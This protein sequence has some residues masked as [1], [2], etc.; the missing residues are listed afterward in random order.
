MEA[1]S[2]CHCQ[3]TRNPGGKRP[4]L[5][6]I[7]K[8]TRI[9]R[10][11][12]EILEPGPLCHEF[13]RLQPLKPMRSAEM[14]HPQSALQWFLP[15]LVFVLKYPLQEVMLEA[16]FSRSPVA[17]QNERWIS[18]PPLSSGPGSG[19]VTSW[20]PLLYAQTLNLATHTRHES[21]GAEKGRLMNSFSRSRGFSAEIGV[22]SM[23]GTSFSQHSATSNRHFE[24]ENTFGTNEWHNDDDS[25]YSTDFSEASDPLK[26]HSR[27]KTAKYIFLTLKQALANSMLIIAI[28]GF[29]FYFI[30]GLTPVDSFYFT[31]VLLTTV[32]Y[33]DI[34]PETTPGKVFATVYLLVAGT[35]LLHNMSLISMIPLELRKRRVEN[36]VLMQF[37]QLDDETLHELATGPLIRRLKLSHQNNGLEECTREMFALAMLVRLGRIKERDVR[38]MLKVFKRLDH[39]NDGKLNSRD[40]IMQQF[41]RRQMQSRKDD[42]VEHDE[43]PP[44]KAK[45][46]TS[47]FRFNRHDA[48]LPKI[49]K[50]RSTVQSGR[51]ETNVNNPEC[52]SLLQDNEHHIERSSTPKIPSRSGNQRAVLD[53]YRSDLESGYGGIQR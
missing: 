32:G 8:T 25:S 1:F 26:P 50:G 47:W 37:E 46:E 38:M 23:V 24:D 30:E 34:Y 9:H 52:I 51:D 29:G 21:L 14:L 42:G 4:N 7:G 12:R 48:K 33:G 13:E 15:V 39:D 11:S 19:S 31:T 18:T 49:A 36:A 41:R 2:G 40:V 10:T 27:M 17:S 44:K 3:I 35:V 45:T 5:P 6:A 20:S 28:G 43:S 22:G 16:F 53:R